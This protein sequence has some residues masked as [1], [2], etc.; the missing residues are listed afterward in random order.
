MEQQYRFAPRRDQISE[1]LITKIIIIRFDRF[2]SYSDRLR[3]IILSIFDSYRHDL[4]KFADFFLFL[5][6]KTS[7]V[8]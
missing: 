2:D 3:I 6:V 1:R 7:R 4:E 5:R 8:E